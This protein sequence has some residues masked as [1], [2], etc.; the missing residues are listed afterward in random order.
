[1]D[2][3]LL[4][5]ISLVFMFLRGSHG[6]RQFESWISG[7]TITGIEDLESTGACSI[8]FSP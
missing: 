3:I 2:I 8:G 5:A 7:E 1:M 6:L 4:I